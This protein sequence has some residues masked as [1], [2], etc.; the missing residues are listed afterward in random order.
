MPTI[1]ENS[2]GKRDYLREKKLD[3]GVG[4][5]CVCLWQFYQDSFAETGCRKN[6]LD[7]GEDRNSQIMGRNQKIRTHCQN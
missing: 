2:T 4:A 7:A 3:S 5:I 1:H 6:N